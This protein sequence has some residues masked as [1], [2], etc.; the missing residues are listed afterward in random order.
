MISIT[1]CLFNSINRNVTPTEMKIT[2]IETLLS[3]A[4]MVHQM[5]FTCKMIENAEH[6]VQ[7]D[8]DL[9]AVALATDVQEGGN[10]VEDNRHLLKHLKKLMSSTKQQNLKQKQ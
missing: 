3:K 5:I 7:H 8:D 1:R 10:V 6:C 9:H 2:K 4:T